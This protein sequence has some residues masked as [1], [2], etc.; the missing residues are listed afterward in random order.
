MQVS[1]IFA[2]N[3]FDGCSICLRICTCLYNIYQYDLST[4]LSGDLV[5]KLEWNAQK[6]RVLLYSCHKYLAV[7]L[8]RRTTPEYV[9]MCMTVARQCTNALRVQMYCEIGVKRPAHFGQLEF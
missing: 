5:L 2:R 6:T 9:T 8:G 7:L 4:T 3:S 1:Q